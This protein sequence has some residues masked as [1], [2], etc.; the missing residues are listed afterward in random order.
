MTGLLN[1]LNAIEAS[2]AGLGRAVVQLLRPGLVARDVESRVAERQLPMSADLR[3][4]YEWRNGTNTGVGLALDDLHFVPGFYLLSL[5]DALANYDAFAVSPRW[6][7]SW[8]PVLANGGGDFLVL[9]LSK[10]GTGASVRHFR[11]EQSDHPIE[12]ESLAEMFATFEQAFVQGVFYVD[13]AGYFEMDDT[14]YA[15]LAASLN[16]RVAW[17]KE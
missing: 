16:P 12:Y 2:L 15:A 5:D 6:D 17:W 14:A 1:H 8:V 9:D 3:T 13:S 11:I 10:G 4:L 7:P